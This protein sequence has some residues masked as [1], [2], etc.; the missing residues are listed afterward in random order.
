[1]RG[2]KIAC[3]GEEKIM[4]RLSYLRMFSVIT[5]VITLTSVAEAALTVDNFEAGAFTLVQTWPKSASGVQN[6]LNSSDVI[7][8]QRQ[9][10][11]VNT[12]GGSTAALALTTGDDGVVYQQSSS[13][14]T[15]VLILTYG[16]TNQLNLDLTQLGL[17]AL[18]VELSSASAYGRIE[19]TI[20]TAVGTDDECETSTP[21]GYLP[22]SGAGTYLIN[23]VD[24]VPDYGTPNFSDVDTIYFGISV[25][26]LPMNAF[27]TVADI[28]L[29][30]EPTTLALLGLGGLL[31][32]KKK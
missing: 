31:L 1:V 2:K 5:A 21:S 27:Y 7:G 3:T 22:I 9:E 26:A 17:N 30:P 25:P 19:L 20:A 12:L 23:L 10:L 13:N 29:V 14:T 24:L 32:R 28:T 11:L 16:G 18:C 6:G 8:G 15:G 4:N